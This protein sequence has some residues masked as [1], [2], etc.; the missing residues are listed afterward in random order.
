[1][2]SRPKPYGVRVNLRPGDP[3]RRIMVAAWHRVRWFGEALRLIQRALARS[4]GIRGTTAFYTVYD[5][6]GSQMHDFS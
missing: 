3:F 1:M 2:S 5:P 6:P 4:H